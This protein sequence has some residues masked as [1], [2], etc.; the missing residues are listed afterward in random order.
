MINAGTQ[1]PGQI[2]APDANYPY[3]GAKNETVPSA[4]DGTPFEKAML[5][6]IFGLQQGLL[7]ASGIVP[8]GNSDTVLVSDQMQAL[9]HLVTAGAF[10]EDSGAA[11]AYIIDP[12][13]NG[14]GP[15]AYNDGMR[16]RFIPGN[17]NTGASTV[18]VGGLGAKDIKTPEG[19][20]PII[21][22][23]LAGISITIE[24]D[25]AGDKFVIYSVATGGATDKPYA[26]IEDQRTQNTPGGTF[27]SGAWQTRTLNQEVTDAKGI[28]SLAAN[29]ITL[30]A[31]T[32][33]FRASAPASAVD[34]HQIRLYNITDASAT[35]IGTSEIAAGSAQTR[36]VVSVR[37]TI[38]AAKVFELQHRCETTRATDGFGNEANLT[39][40]IFAR[41]EIMKEI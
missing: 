31:G 20:D 10:M 38:T 32:Y 26:L 4:F 22:D 29:Q 15:E 11:D 34:R 24:Y 35:K 25:L 28:A 13:A 8:S 14:F 19:N 17:D 2:E 30:Q 23:I 12:I 37:F 3:G 5:A 9:I 7:N 33:K 18:D 6:D 36:S 21:G 41:I 27:T 39:T 16:F 1:Y 40:E